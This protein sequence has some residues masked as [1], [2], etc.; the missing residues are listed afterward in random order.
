MCTA[1]QVAGSYTLSLCEGRVPYR[2]S[3]MKIYS[4]VQEQGEYA[5]MALGGSAVKSAPSRLNRDTQT[6]RQTQVS[7]TGTRRQTAHAK[8]PSHYPSTIQQENM[9]ICMYVCM[10][11]E[12]Q[13]M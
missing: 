3:G 8:G 10:C 12:V 5:I 2:V 7:D 1:W 13:E 4:S 11:G 9:H 6:D